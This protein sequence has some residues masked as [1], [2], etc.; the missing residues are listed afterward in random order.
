V[1]IFIEGLAQ[2]IRWEIALEAGKN[3]DAEIKAK[4]GK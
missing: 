2:F 4:L 1:N 3:I